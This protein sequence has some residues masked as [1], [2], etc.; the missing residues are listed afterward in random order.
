MLELV[1]KFGVTLVP[2]DEGG[3]MIHGECDQLTTN[4]L[5]LH[6]EKIIAFANN[7]NHIKADLSKGQQSLTDEYERCLELLDLWERIEKGYRAFFPDDTSCVHGDEGCARYSII[8][9]KACSGQ[10]PEKETP[11]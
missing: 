9:C 1:Q 6:R 11:G 7:K 3:V 10:T 5:K 2:D 8:S 4:T